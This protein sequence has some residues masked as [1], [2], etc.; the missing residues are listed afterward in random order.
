MIVRIRPCTRER[1]FSLDDVALLLRA[2]RSGSGEI[3]CPECDGRCEAV[4]DGHR[5]SLTIL[6]C[7]VCERGVLVENP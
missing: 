3:R 1:R 6:R 5:G 2:R 4:S 7:T